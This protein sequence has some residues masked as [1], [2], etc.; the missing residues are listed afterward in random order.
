MRIIILLYNSSVQAQHFYSVRFQPKSH[1]PGQLVPLITRPFQTE[2]VVANLITSQTWDK[3]G[4]L[5][6]H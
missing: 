2:T 3:K 6:V 1:N 4:T 5:A